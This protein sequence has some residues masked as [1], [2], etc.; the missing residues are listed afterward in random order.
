MIS[1]GSP[2][3][4]GA[5]RHLL[6]VTVEDYFH[7]SAFNRL[8]EPRLW[9]RF[10]AR[11]ELNIARTLDLLDEYGVKATFFVL[12]WTADHHPAAIAEI[13]RRGHEVA[14]KGYHHREFGEMGIEEFRADL[15]RSRDAVERAAGR[16]VVGYRVST[17]VLTRADLWA[18]DVLA[19]EGFRYDS[20]AYPMFRE[21]AAEPW[22]RSPYV[23][24]A[25]GR[26]IHEV[27]ISTC[28]PRAFALPIGGGNWFRQL[29][30]C[31]MKRA[32]RRQAAR[33][34]APLVLYFHVWELDPD[35]PRIATAGSL[36]RIRQ[37]RHLDRMESLLRFYL[38]TYR[39]Q[40]IAQGLGIPREAAAARRAAPEPAPFAR[41]AAPAGGGAQCVPVTIVVPCHNEELTIPYLANTLRELIADLGADY[42]VRFVFVDD[43]STDGTYAALC[44][45]FGSWRNIEFERHGTNRG[46]A[47]A[48]LTG[49]RKARTEIV[50]S[51]DCDCSYD[52]MQLRRMIPLLG[53]DV[54]LVTASPYHPQGEVRNV[55]CWRLALSKGLSLLYRVSLRRDISTYTSC[56]R[57]YRR[58]R[59]IDLPVRSG[60]FL[61]IAE[62]IVLLALRGERIV[63]MPAVLETRMLGRSKITLCKTIA[64]HLGLLARLWTGR[65]RPR[66]QS[67]PAT[68]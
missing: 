14:C 48:I 11:L 64:G 59:V 23:H 56:F 47:A 30:H 53:E 27:P 26:E 5:R 13:D 21:A 32:V 8:I 40:P 18:L 67:P 19:E 62:M 7:V 3:L 10:E 15:R 60:G 49:I 41:E 25:Q 58:S 63:E 45:V 24:R 2:S 66:A 39:F 42:E 61:G 28:G 17:G 34:G 29:P 51:I 54:T 9:A 31:L 6:T 50:C 52:P 35:L 1:P 16:R 22:R 68:N 4:N 20:S 36:T 46:V 43:A 55:P 44:S 12:G 38:E 57:V 37:Y 33:G 65:F